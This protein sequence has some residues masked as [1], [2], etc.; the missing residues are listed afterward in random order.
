MIITETW[1]RCG[2]A[3]ATPIGSKVLAVFLCSVAGERWTGGGDTGG[4]GGES[5][6]LKRLR[7]PST[8]ALFVD[9]DVR[10][11]GEDLSATGQAAVPGDRS[12]TASR[13]DPIVFVSCGQI[14]RAAKTGS[15]AQ[16]HRSFS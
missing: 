8:T 3:H 13:W 11:G 14:M 5:V 9:R 7:M 15:A 1:R 10:R 16:A 2:L 12:H 6:K 4:G